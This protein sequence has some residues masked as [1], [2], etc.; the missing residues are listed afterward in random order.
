[1]SA[2]NRRVPKMNDDYKA[3][4]IAKNNKPELQIHRP[5]GMRRHL[6][7]LGGALGL[8]KANKEQLKSM[9]SSQTVFVPVYNREFQC[10]VV[11]SFWGFVK[12]DESRIRLL[13]FLCWCMQP[14]MY[15]AGETKEG[16]HVEAIMIVRLDR[17]H[18]QRDAFK[19]WLDLFFDRLQISAGTVVFQEYLGEQM[20]TSMDRIQRSQKLHTNMYADWNKDFLMLYQM[21]SQNRAHQQ[22]VLSVTGIPLTADNFVEMFHNNTNGRGNVHRPS[23]SI[24]Q[25]WNWRWSHSLPR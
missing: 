18:I 24:A 23:R 21:L 12:N 5:S 6:Q 8:D 1:M 2:D 9:F 10:E 7:R 3:E 19:S 16:H 17:L 15:M 11:F 22:R 4:N 25:E 13:D 20:L 14:R